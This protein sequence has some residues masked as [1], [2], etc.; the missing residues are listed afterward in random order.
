MTDEERQIEIERGAVQDGAARYRESVIAA[1]TKFN[2][3]DTPPGERFTNRV[4]RKFVPAVVK[5]QREMKKR[6]LE[7]SN[8]PVLDAQIVPILTLPPDVL[9]VITLRTIMSGDGNRSFMFACR[10]I[11]RN[12]KL[13][14]DWRRFRAEERAKKK[15]DPDHFDVALRAIGALSENW[16][17]HKQAAVGAVMLHC[18]ADACPAE[19]EIVEYTNRDKHVRTLRTFDMTAKTREG[20]DKVHDVVA[21]L[22]PWRC[23][24]VVPPKPWKEVKE[25]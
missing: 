7:V 22:H 5:L 4:M 15:E 25:R 16:S 18:L 17:L 2:E 19:F 11:A 8:A 14:I 1:Q 3:M 20:L 24:M 23:P 10:S 9:A 6:S 21:M 13:E 12:V